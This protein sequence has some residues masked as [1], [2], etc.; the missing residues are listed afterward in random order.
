MAGVWWACGNPVGKSH[1]A[2]RLF[3]QYEFIEDVYISGTVLCHENGIMKK[4]YNS[5]ALGVELK[6]PGS[7]LS[8]S[9]LSI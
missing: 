7:L 4:T 6:K 2:S 5:K 3:I 1:T 9:V 8:S